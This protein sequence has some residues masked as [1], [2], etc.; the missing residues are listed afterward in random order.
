M[1]WRGRSS[2]EW[3]EPQH[4]RPERP[5]E[6]TGRE[7][8]AGS[9]TDGDPADPVLSDPLLDAV[10]GDAHAG[11]ANVA[12][13]RAEQRDVATRDA[14]Q[15]LVVQG[16]PGTDRAGLALR[17]VAWL[18]DRFGDRLGSDD[19]LVVGPSAAFLRRLRELAPDLDGEMT[20]VPL[21][22][23]GPRVRASRLDPPDLRR[24]KGDRRLR[25]VI[26][27]ALRHHERIPTAA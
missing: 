11:P 22:G 18:L 17:R 19:I 27:R 3:G 1:N 6:R 7:P 26:K 2:L 16:G 5:Q 10:A 21:S 9:P 14:D 12:A 15:L 4:M 20:S 13:I 24:L 23:L 25:R 8:P